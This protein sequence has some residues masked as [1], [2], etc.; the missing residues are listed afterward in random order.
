MEG[1]TYLEIA[2]SLESA[3][4]E[5]ETAPEEAELEANVQSV[6]EGI[7]IV[8][9]GSQYS[10]LIA[11]RVRELKVYSEI[12]PASSSWDSIEHI[13]PKGVI[14]S[15]GPASVFEPGAPTVPDWVFER[16]LSILGSCDG[17]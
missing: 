13:N 8:D 1:S 17:M 2:R 16:G 3:G 10:H 4:S 9:F 15:G 5:V 6:N 12:V 11:R 7:V 14:L